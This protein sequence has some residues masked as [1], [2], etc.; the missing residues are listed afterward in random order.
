MEP[1]NDACAVPGAQFRHVDE[2][3][4]LA[5]VPGEHRLHLVCCA[6]NAKLP[7]AQ[8][9]QFGEPVKPEKLPG[10]HATQTDEF[11]SENDP[12]EQFK[13][14]VTIPCEMLPALHGEHEGA[15]SGRMAYEPDAHPLHID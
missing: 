15:P 13:H 3:L 14:E 6:F 1:P 8:F 4:A 5:N 9:V 2:L 12:V 7:G 10:A 11:E